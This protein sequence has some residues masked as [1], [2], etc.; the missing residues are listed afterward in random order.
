MTKKLGQKFKNSVNEKSFKDEI[1]VFFIIFKGIA[2][3]QIKQIILESDTSN[4]VLLM[5]ICLR[6]F[7]VICKTQIGQWK[8][9]KGVIYLRQER[10]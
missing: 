3:K 7:Y 5:I 10:H 1:K 8:S 4:L 6:I 2:L 9:T